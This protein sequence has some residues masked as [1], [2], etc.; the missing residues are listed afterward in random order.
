[1]SDKDGWPKD[2]EITFK[3]YPEALKAFLVRTGYISA[4]WRPPEEREN[5]RPHD[6]P[7]PNDNTA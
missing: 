6:L 2:Q 3:S 5:V 1:V 7:S 4:A